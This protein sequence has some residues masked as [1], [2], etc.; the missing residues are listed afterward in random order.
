MLRS[1]KSKVDNVGH[2]KN[3]EKRISLNRSKKHKRK[4]EKKKKE[5]MMMKKEEE[6]EGSRSRNSGPG[7]PNT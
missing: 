5:M 4:E 7:E 2:M 3:E 6:E 1:F